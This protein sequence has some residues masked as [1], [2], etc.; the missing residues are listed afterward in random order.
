MV[1]LWASEQNGRRVCDGCVPNSKRDFFVKVDVHYRNHTFNTNDQARCG[2]T[3]ISRHTVITAAHCVVIKDST[4]T[5][6]EIN[7]K[8]F[9]TRIDSSLFFDKK[10]G[11]AITKSGT[12][13]DFQKH[14][15]V[16]PG[17]NERLHFLYDI[18]L[19]NFQPEKFQQ[20]S[21]LPL[22]K[23]KDI[24][25]HMRILGLFKKIKGQPPADLIQKGRKFLE[26]KK[27]SLV[28][29]KEVHES[30]DNVSCN[31]KLGLTNFYKPAL[32]LCLHGPNTH[33]GDSGGPVFSAE[34]YPGKKGEYKYKPV[35]LF[36]VLSGVTLLGNE[37]ATRVSA[38]SDW[39]EENMKTN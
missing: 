25:T 28:Q 13:N 14:L 19:I 39:I 32:H 24:H 11:L 4:V 27:T 6:I 8:D 23:A 36:G 9:T 18:A 10:A 12:E 7:Y 20:E 21:V 2:G 16:H 22:C 35:C 26:G 17:Y 30:V 38:T 29:E 3:I 15:I 33:Y 31:P 37:L 5:R 1:S 34:P